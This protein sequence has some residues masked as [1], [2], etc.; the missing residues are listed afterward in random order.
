MSEQR[1]IQVIEDLEKARE[2]IAI[3]G[4]PVAIEQ[5]LKYSIRRLKSVLGQ[6]PAS[7]ESS[8]LSAETEDEIILTHK[9]VSGSATTACCNRTPF[10]LPRGDKIEVLDINARYCDGN[11][12]G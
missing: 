7:E 11:E 2:K 6:L 4:K 10:E 5:T 1:L 9:V 8:V 12:H 3:Y